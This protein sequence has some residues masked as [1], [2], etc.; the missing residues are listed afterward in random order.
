MKCN[1][2]HNRQ[3]FTAWST[4]VNSCYFLPVIAFQLR[5]NLYNCFPRLFD[6]SSS[7]RSGEGSWTC[8]LIGCSMWAVMKLSSDE[9]IFLSLVQ[10][11]WSWIKHLM[12]H[13]YTTQ[14]LI[15]HQVFVWWLFIQN[16]NN[17]C[18]A[19]ILGTH[20]GMA[21]YSSANVSFQHPLASLR[22][23]DIHTQTHTVY[24]THR[25]KGISPTV[26]LAWLICLEWNE[27]V[28]SQQPVSVGLG[29]KSRIIIQMRAF[30]L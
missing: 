27:T 2:H 25:G 15:L 14:S 1:D 7:Y 22:L 17:V 10:Q 6:L 18:A 24:D 3:E 19:F 11:W 5:V 28:S 30:C 16:E 23:D 20:Y 4:A 26:W 13:L 29:A 8:S 21:I 9:D 12:D